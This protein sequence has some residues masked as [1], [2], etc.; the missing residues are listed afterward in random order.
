MMLSLSQKM[1]YVRSWLFFHS[2]LILLS[3]PFRKAI[4]KKIR[5]NLGHCNNRVVGWLRINL[6]LQTVYKISIFILVAFVHLNFFLICLPTAIVWV[7]G[8]LLG[9]LSQVWKDFFVDGFPY[10]KWGCLPYK[11]KIMLSFI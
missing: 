3:I 2:K 5:S 4:K 10:K 8:R 6:I 7:G 1:S 11:K 9:T